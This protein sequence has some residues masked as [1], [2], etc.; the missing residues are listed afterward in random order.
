MD[1]QTAAAAT[2]SGDTAAVPTGAANANGAT[3]GGNATATAL[4]MCHSNF[5]ALLPSCIPLQYKWPAKSTPKKCVN[6]RQK[7]PRDKTV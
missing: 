1:Q 6:L 3:G 5:H 4:S 2:A 7:L